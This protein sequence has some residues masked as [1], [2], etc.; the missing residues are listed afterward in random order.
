MELKKLLSKALQKRYIA[1]ATIN[2]IEGQIKKA[3]E[4][5]T[6]DNYYEERLY[7]DDLEYKLE[8]VHAHLYLHWRSTTLDDRVYLSLWYFCSSKLPKAKRERVK[9][10][11]EEC[12]LRNYIPP[13]N[14]KPPLWYELKY[15]IDIEDV[16]AK[17]ISL[18]IEL[19]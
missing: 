11:K 4:E 19:P 7:L 18:L 5:I 17:D 15:S 13:S 10:V 9:K 6:F 14:H 2:H 16:F 3:A 12:R 1:S 8:R